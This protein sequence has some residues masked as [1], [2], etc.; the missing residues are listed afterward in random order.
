VSWSNRFD[1]L[2]SL[3]ERRQ[4]ANLKQAAH[5]IMALPKAEQNLSE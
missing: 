1:D 3:A 2:I 4:L 5:Y